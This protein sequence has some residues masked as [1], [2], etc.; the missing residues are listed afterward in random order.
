M[1]S[2]KDVASLASEYLE[3]DLSSRRRWSLRF[4]LFLCVD[5]RK[6]VEGIRSVMRLAPTLRASGEPERFQDLAQRLTAGFSNGPDGAPRP[7]EGGDTTPE[8][9]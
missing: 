7:G 5:C 1:M 8:D 4:H 6:F 9:R 2:C 3:K